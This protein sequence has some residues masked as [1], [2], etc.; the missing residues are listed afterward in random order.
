MV[1]TPRVIVPVDV[2]HDD[3]VPEA[4]V[5]FLSS[6]PVVVLG[7]HEIP[8]QTMPEQARAE[9]EAEASEAL[10]ELAAAFASHDA[11]VE[12]E[13]VFTHDPA[14]AIQRAVEDVD[15][16]VVLHPNPIRSVDDVL[17]EVGVPALAP[18]TAAATAAL[19]GPTDARI[20]L[21][22]VTDDDGSSGETTL[23]G[24]STAL[25]AAG[26]APHR[27]SQVVERTGERE[28][29]I[30]D[31]AEGHDL[32]VIGDEE[33]GILDWLFGE[34]SGRIAERTLAPVLV[35]QPPFER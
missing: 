25:D 10:K 11:P 34:T 14:E 6:V 33:P 7:Y 16:G 26:I 28:A 1:G 13:L 19:V 17:V 9:H 29:A 32:L 2:L 35:V 5:E 12:T 23:S 31:H 18:A 20:T 21:L 30:I 22:H 27:V 3:V 15:R 4:L 24:I 8:V